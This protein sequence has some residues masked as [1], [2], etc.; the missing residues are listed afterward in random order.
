MDARLWHFLGS[1]MVGL[2]A[3]PFFLLALRACRPRAVSFF[4][5][6]GFARCTGENSDF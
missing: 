5:K 4:Q 6:L 1:Q 3:R 2:K